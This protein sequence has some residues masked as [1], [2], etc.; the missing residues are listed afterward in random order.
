[1]IKH[2]RLFLL[3][4]YRDICNIAQEKSLSRVCLFRTI[5]SVPFRT[6]VFARYICMDYVVCFVFFMPC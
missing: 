5:Q 1:M 3:S 4:L 6:L 2:N